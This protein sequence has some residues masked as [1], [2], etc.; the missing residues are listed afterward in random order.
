MS[1]YISFDNIKKAGLLCCLLTQSLVIYADPIDTVV[2]KS[3]VAAVPDDQDRQAEFNFPNWPDRQH[4][5]KES[6]PPPPPG[7]YMSLGLNEFPV[8]E[9]PFDSKHKKPQIEVDSS[10][11]PLQTFNPD[12]PWPKNIRPTKR[13]MPE[14][15]YQYVDPQ[16]AKKPYPTAQNYPAYNNYNYGYPRNP[17]MRWPGSNWAPSMAA[18]PY[19]YAPQYGPGYSNPVNNNYIQPGN[20][21]YRTPYPVPGKP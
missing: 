21:S 8:S 19:G 9:S 1:F 16:V 2:T 17:D 5:M 13:W 4:V 15:G 6:L 18:G 10:G 7:P 12:V 11:V 3:E 20:S 14:K